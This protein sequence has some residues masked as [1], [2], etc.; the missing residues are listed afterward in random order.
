MSTTEPGPP[1]AGEAVPDPSPQP[2]PATAPPVPAQVLAVPQAGLDS[3]PGER[4]R[5]L[6][7]GGG[8]AGLVAAYELRRQGHDPVVLEAQNRVGGRIYTLRNFAPGLYAEAGAMR[9][10]RAHDLTLEYC[11]LFD[12][13]LRPFVMGNPRGLVYIGGVRMS[14]ADAQISPERLPYQLEEHERGKSA[15]QLWQDAI[16][17][18]REMVDSAGE[19][20]WAE[21]VRRYDEYSLYEFLKARGLSE[22]AIE[23]YAV[24]NFVEADMHN[25]VVEILREDL[26]GAYVDMSTIV[27]GMDLLPN[28][29]YAQLQ[30][31]VRFG[32]EVRRIEQDAD[33]V[34]LR[35]RVARLRRA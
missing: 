5:V 8:I 19:Q 11:R 26:G 29:F 9:I 17:E 18:I 27:G 22:E 3:H 10:P 30:D 33:G 12:L 23:Y 31:A 2:S 24:M 15:D 28:A 32:V 13:P 20:A 16:A 7:I 25:A 6:I 34:R 1:P 21:I 35:C 4:K 14:A